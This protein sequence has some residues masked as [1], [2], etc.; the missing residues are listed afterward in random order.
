MILKWL[1]RDINSVHSSSHTRH[2]GPRTGLGMGEYR[3][4]SYAGSRKNAEIFTRTEGNVFS[5]SASVSQS[6]YRGSARVGVPSERPVSGGLLDVLHHLQ[7]LV[8]VEP[9]I[10]VAVRVVHDL[11]DVL[12]GQVLPSSMNDLTKLLAVDEAVTIFVEDAKDFRKF[13]FSFSRLVLL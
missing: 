7:E 4:A 1:G 6:Q 9:S 10:L 12:L 13:C 3:T 5:L 2:T 8:K 11:I